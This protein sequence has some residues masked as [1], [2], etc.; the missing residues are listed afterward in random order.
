MGC[1][2]GA[3]GLAIAARNENVSVT[4]IDS[5]ARA[6]ECTEHGARLNELSNITAVHTADGE[7]AGQGTFD[8]F[9]GNPPYFSNYRIAELFLKTAAKMLK[10]G[11][12]VL[13][14]CKK[15]DWYHE[16]MAKFFDGVGFAK[17]GAYNI[18]GGVQRG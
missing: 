13:I 10:P 11:G 17:S 7:C 3:V 6:I 9:L 16:R 18:V 1:G 5:N 2:S 14:V 12:E 15:T 8:L 4:G